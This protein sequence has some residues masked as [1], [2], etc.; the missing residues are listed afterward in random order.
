MLWIWFDSIT[1]ALAKLSHCLRPSPVLLYQAAQINIRRRVHILLTNIRFSLRFSKH[2][3]DPF[4]CHSYMPTNKQTSDSQIS[5]WIQL[6]FLVKHTLI[7]CF[8]FYYFWCIIKCW[9]VERYWL[10]KTL[11]S[12]YS[13]AVWKSLK[14]KMTLEKNIS[15]KIQPF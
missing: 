9:S 4:S 15:Y 12:L 1:A 2:F 11:S 10:S 13:N 8:I 3:N 5:A 6:Y 7:I 14:I